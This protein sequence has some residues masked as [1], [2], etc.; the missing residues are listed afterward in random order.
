MPAQSKAA[1]VTVIADDA[2]LSDALATACYLR[3]HE[4][5]AHYTNARAI[6]VDPDGTTF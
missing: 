4:P 5:A 2:M 6:F 3:G 1:S